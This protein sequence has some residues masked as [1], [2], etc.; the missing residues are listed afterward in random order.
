MEEGDQPSVIAFF[1]NP[2]EL[3]SKCLGKM[4]LAAAGQMNEP[5]GSDTQ[6]VVVGRVVGIGQESRMFL[7]RRDVDIRASLHAE[8]FVRAL[9]V[10]LLN[11]LVETFL[12]LE[13][14]TARRASRFGFECSVHSLVPTVF[15]G[16]SGSNA[17]QLD[18][19]SK[20]VGR[21]PGEPCQPSARERHPVVRAHR[22]RDPS[23]PEYLLA[24]LACGLV[25]DRSHTFAPDDEAAELISNRQGIAVGVI[26]EPK[27]ALVVDAPDIVRGSSLA[28][29]GG[30]WSESSPL[31]SK[32]S[33]HAPR[34]RRR[35]C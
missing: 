31:A 30:L 15:L 7:G 27:L 11:E 10:E 21:E 24:D 12:L 34:I 33:A 18:A 29:S 25:A 17:L 5:L 20:P 28:K 35:S 19:K 14:V 6:D 1:A 9:G 13:Q 32:G 22:R 2:D 23:D 4:H 3:P 8:S 26:P 16:V